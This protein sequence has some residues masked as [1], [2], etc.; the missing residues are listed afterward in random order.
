LGLTIAFV[1]L[2]LW[3]LIPFLISLKIFKQKD[4]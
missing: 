3:I 2:M 4:L 1:L